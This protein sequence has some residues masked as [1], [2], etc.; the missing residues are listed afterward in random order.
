MCVCDG[1]REMGN[2]ISPL[3]LM[4][5]KSIRLSSVYV[6]DGRRRGDGMQIHP[7]NINSCARVSSFLSPVLLIGFRTTSPL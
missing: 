3:T 2:S 1:E 5:G 4:L 6:C 7:L